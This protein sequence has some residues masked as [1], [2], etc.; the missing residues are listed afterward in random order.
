MSIH[1]D[2]IALCQLCSV[3]LSTPLI[4]SDHHLSLQ[5]LGIFPKIIFPPKGWTEHLLDKD[6]SRITGTQI[7]YIAPAFIS[8]PTETPGPDIYCL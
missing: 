4:K 6:T 2:S 8:E 7:G 3:W 5:F 1:P